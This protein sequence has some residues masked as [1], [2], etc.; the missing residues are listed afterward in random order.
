[1]RG[2]GEV[3]PECPIQVEE[4]V[5]VADVVWVSP[6]RYQKISKQDICLIAPE[7]CIEVLSDSN[8]TRE[9]QSKIYQY[10]KT[11]AQEVWVCD[12]A[13]QMQFFSA[14]GLLITSQ[15]IPDFPNTVPID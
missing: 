5:K 15:L 3:F 4:G 8:T 6:E 9:M 13:G 1:M 2:V 14:V 10:L 7:I 11:G 12:S